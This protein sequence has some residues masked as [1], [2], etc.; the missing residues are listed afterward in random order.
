MKEIKF[1]GKRVDNGEWA[2]GYLFSY[3]INSFIV[4]EKDFIC[5]ENNSTAPTI[6]ELRTFG[7][8]VIPETVGQYIGLKDKNGV[9]IYEG[10][11]VRVYGGEYCQGYWEYDQEILVGNNLCDFYKL[12]QY[13]LSQA[14]HIEVIGNIHDTNYCG[15]C[16]QKLK[17]AD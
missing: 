5:Y 1:K 16:G 10:D 14:D 3:G 12:S 6:C 7:N 9:E 11:V 13:E 8:R 2:Y 17:E 4:G 15:N